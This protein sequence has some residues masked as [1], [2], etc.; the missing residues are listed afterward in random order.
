MINIFPGSLKPLCTRS[1]LAGV[2]ILGLASPALAQPK[3]QQPEPRLMMSSIDLREPVDQAWQIRIAGEVPSRAGMMLIMFDAQ[4]KLHLKQ[5]LPYGVYP[6]DQPLVI[7]MPADGI[8]GD[9]RLIA[10]GFQ[11]DIRGLL[12]PVSTLPL[13]VYSGTYFAA[14]NTP[15]ILFKA[16]PGVEVYHI[17]SYLVGQQLYEGDEVVLDTQKNGV[18]EGRNWFAPLKPR[19]DAVYSFRK[20]NVFYF[21]AKE[22]LHLCFDIQRWFVPDPKLNDIKW[23]ELTK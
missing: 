7:D 9:Y 8:T 17:R 23:W 2:M 14:R 6:A 4:G 10:I 21:G 20:M 5:H 1:L 15:P 13:E 16:A 18:Q 22:P 11:E 19:P 12:L 3:D